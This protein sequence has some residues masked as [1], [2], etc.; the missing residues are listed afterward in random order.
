MLDT[1]TTII[2]NPFNL[3]LHLC[4]HQYD[5]AHDIH[6]ITLPATHEAV[7]EILTIFDVLNQRQPPSGLNRMLIETP[8]RVMPPLNP[9]FKGALEMNR[10]YPQRAP[11]RIALPVNKQTLFMN[12]IDAFLRL[13]RTRD[14]IRSFEREQVA[15]DWLRTTR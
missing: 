15:L 4:D 14:V 2:A 11:Y 1:P 13:I 8:G 9:L 3:V 7:A 5:A 12:V 10:K 6:S